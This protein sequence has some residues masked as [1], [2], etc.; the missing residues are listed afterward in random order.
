MEQLFNRYMELSKKTYEYCKGVSLYPSEI[1]TIS[2][3][4]ESSTVNLTDISNYLGMSRGAITKM[5]GKL[6]KMGLLERYKYYPNQKEI[7]VHLTPLGVEAYEGHVR[8]HE[9]M[10]KRLSGY[11]EKLPSEKQMLILEFLEL[12]LDQMFCLED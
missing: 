12:Y 3:I 9:K 5:I 11:Y 7:Y 1:H 8:Y 4:A 2:F 6:E 10:W